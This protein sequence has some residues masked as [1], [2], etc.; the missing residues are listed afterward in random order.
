MRFNPVFSFLKT[1]WYA[2]RGYIHFPKS[3]NNQTLVMEDGHKFT[4]FRQVVIGSSSDIP[5]EPGT[6]LKVRFHLSGM[7]PQKNKSFS[8]IPM[9]FF[10][11]LPGFRSKFWTLNESNGYFQGIYQW[12]TL[13]YAKKYTKS[14]AFRFMTKRSTPDSVSYKIIPNKSMKEYIDILTKK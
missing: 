6:I 14:F 12:K 4:V 2:L 9:P 13:E 5:K 1:L 11:G 10:I 3:L 7:T 8:C